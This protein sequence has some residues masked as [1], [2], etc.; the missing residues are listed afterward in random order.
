MA[1]AVAKVSKAAVPAPPKLP[2]WQWSG[3]ARGGVVRKGKME[4][5]D[6]ATVRGRLS[7]MGIQPTSVRRP[8]GSLEL[9]IKIPGLAP[10]VKTT[11]LL[12]FTRQFSVM[13]DAG[14]PLV[15]ALEIIGGQASNPTFRTVLLTVK[16]KVEA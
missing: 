11:D 15:Q 1:E 12:V 10:R 6:E 5:V 8:L 3:K 14:L 13:V 16:A 4:A 7:Q 9:K 2:T